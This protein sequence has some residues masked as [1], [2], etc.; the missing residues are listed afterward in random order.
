MKQYKVIVIGAG[1]S[2]ICMGIKL[3]Q[4]GIDDFVILEKA[5]GLGGTWRENTYPGAECDIPSALYSYS[6]EHNDKWE[7]KW[8]GQRQ[9]LKYQQDTAAK[10]RLN[11]NIQFGTEV[12][13][14][15]FD[16][17]DNRWLV[18]TSQGEQIVAQHL[19]AGVGQLHHPAT[20]KFAGQDQFRGHQFHSAQWQHDVDLR[21][22][23]VA[24]I[25]NAASAVQF[26]PEIARDVAHLTIFQR[27]ANW[28]IPKVDKPYTRFD[29]W[30]SKHFPPIT[31]LYRFG[32]W[33]R[34]EGVVL[35]A[36]R[37]NRLARWILH[38]WNRRSLKEHISDPELRE[39]LT[40]AYPVGAKRILFS[41]NYYPALARENV[42][43]E[44]EPIE[45]FTEHGI[46]YGKDQQANFDVIIYGTGFKTNP[47]LAPMHITGLDGQTL[48]ESWREGAHAYFGVA[49]AGFPN[50]HMLYGPNTNLGHN[51]II[52]MIEAQVAHITRCIQRL[53]DRSLAAMD[54]KPEVEASFNQALQQRLGALAFSKVENS[55]YM[56]GGK[57]TNNWA[58][59]TQE[60]RRRL[61]KIDWQH[62]NYRPI[63]N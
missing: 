14:S 33:L 51:S 32:L 31:K 46:R 39:K 15:T 63:A 40:P 38:T 7:Y 36:I 52:I 49:T 22:K 5:Q 3:R 10:Y 59:S 50:L 13:A 34:G 44:T 42:H 58:G 60:Y 16:A 11:D 1:F 24:V 6:F 56:D 53:D 45:R 62:Y 23:R 2:G 30:V 43:L 47:F 55:W 28:V 35:P 54:I 9:I 41:D 48:H 25:G 19:V 57:I 29:Q 20:P 61:R 21:G 18:E 12:K 27:S 17:Q 4:M 8:S 37:G 26:I